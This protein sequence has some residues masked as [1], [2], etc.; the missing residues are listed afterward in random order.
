MRDGSRAEFSASDRAF[1]VGLAKRFA[2]RAFAEIFVHAR[3]AAHVHADAADQLKF[4]FRLLCLVIV[5]RG[6][7]NR[8]V[9]QLDAAVLRVLRR[10][11]TR[12][13]EFLHGRFWIEAERYLRIDLRSEHIHHRHAGLDSHRPINCVTE[14]ENRGA[15]PIHDV[16]AVSAARECEPKVGFIF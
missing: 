4:Q 11:L 2:A 12:E 9:L 8:H 15:L 6:P 7:G 10:N 3:A 16:G 5:K 14:I 1:C 13:I